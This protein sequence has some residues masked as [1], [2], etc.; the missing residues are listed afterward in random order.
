MKNLL[1]LIP[2][3]LFV[4][5]FSIEHVAAKQNNVQ[6]VTLKVNS[7]RQAAQLVKQR[8]GGKILKVAKLQQGY[9]V[10]VLKS[11]GKVI[12]V[13]VNARTGNMVRH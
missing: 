11:N 4:N 5:I 3:I 10:K 12:K 9:M 13:F 2:L 8:S 6:A 1:F 7:A